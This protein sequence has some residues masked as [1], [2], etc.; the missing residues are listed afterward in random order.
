MLGLFL[1][2][3]G[4]VFIQTP[5]VQNLASRR[6]KG[7][8]FLA[9]ANF[10][11]KVKKQKIFVSGGRGRGRGRGGQSRRGRSRSDVSRNLEN[12]SEISNLDVKP[13]LQEVEHE[14][15]HEEE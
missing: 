7:I 8:I 1:G 14:A 13:E 11:A 4:L 9:L 6:Q 5:F 15:E 3:I 2:F 10:S 12:E